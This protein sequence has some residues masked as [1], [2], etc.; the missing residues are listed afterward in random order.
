MTR[1]LISFHQVTKK[2]LKR[3]FQGLDKAW[4][5]E[6]KEF[7][8]ARLRNNKSQK[9]H[10]SLHLDR[11]V[12]KKTGVKIPFCAV[13]NLY[14]KGFVI[15][16]SLL[17]ICPSIGWVILSL[18]SLTV[19]RHVYNYCT[20][21]HQQSQSRVPKQKKAPNQGG[22]YCQCNCA[23]F[24]AIICCVKVTAI[25][26]PGPSCLKADQCLTLLC[27]KAFSLIIFSVIFR[28]SNHQLV[29]KKN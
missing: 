3:F 26:L 9:Q 4:V 20:S 27:S 16:F 17:Y 18:C 25:Y 5:S 24:S 1:I 23:K 15:F 6:I 13:L 7:D 29:D 8:I 2:L 14:F 28:A 12:V 19:S 10:G 21:V 11:L 22:E